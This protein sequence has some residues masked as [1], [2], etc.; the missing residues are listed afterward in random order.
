M[1]DLDQIRIAVADAVAT[2]VGVQSNAYMIS[3]PTP[4]CFFVQPGEVDYNTTMQGG[5]YRW[6][7]VLTGLAS[8]GSTDV[9]AQK[10]LDRWLARTGP[11][12]VRAAI[13][14][15]R[16]L[17][18]VVQEVEVP[19]ASGYRIYQRDGSGG[20]ALGAEWTVIVYARGDE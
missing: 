1:A 11:S 6:E 10:I 12:S 13:E 16:T 7:L 17:G 19:S 15:D 4:P 3:A 14:S 20:V 18:G 5:T 2:I 8:L 9:G